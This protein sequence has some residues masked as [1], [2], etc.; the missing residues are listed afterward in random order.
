M[1]K[2][3][4][5]T[6]PTTTPGYS[7]SISNVLW[8]LETVLIGKSNRFDESVVGV[9]SPAVEETLWVCSNKFL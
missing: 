8:K 3:S 4:L 1:S 7:A 6:Q 5:L 9:S 2:V